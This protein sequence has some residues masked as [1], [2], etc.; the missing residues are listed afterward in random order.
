MSSRSG[1][2]MLHFT[3]IQKL[4]HSNSAYSLCDQ[5]KLNTTFSG[6]GA[7]ASYNDVRRII[8]SVRS[9]WGMVSICDI[10]LN[11][12]ANETAWLADHPEATYNLTN[13]PHLRPAFLLDRCVKRLARDIG[14]GVW[15]DRGLPRGEVSTPEHIETVR[16]LLTNHYLPMV[17]IPELFLP[18]IETC[19]GQLEQR[20]RHGQVVAGD[21]SHNVLT[22][23]QDPQYRRHS[24]TVDMDNAARIYAKKFAHMDNVEERV[25]SSLKQFREDLQCL[26][27]TLI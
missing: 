22:I 10:V 16:D 26:G 19:V 7:E 13:S 8:E 1:Y 25:A 20:L 6:P 24:S 14:E 4:G 5:H 15:V 18:N 3:P 17:R 21:A 11:H 9:E 12:T 23:V 27:T 2:N